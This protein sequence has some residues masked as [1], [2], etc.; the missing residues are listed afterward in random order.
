M[1]K[2]G[3]VL[4]SLSAITTYAVRTQSMTQDSYAEFFAG[5]LENVSLDN[6]GGLQP[7]PA[8][9]EVVVLE[10][11]VIFSAVADS[12]GTLYLGTGNHGSVYRLDPGA[13][14]P[15]LLF[16]P[17]SIMTRALAIDEAGNLY[18]GTSPDGAVYRISPNGR[19]E[20][21]FDPPGLYI[22]D[23]KF[24]DDGNLYVATGGDAKIYKLPPNFGLNDEPIEYFSSDRT[25]FTRMAWDRNGDLIVGSG[26]DAYLYRIKGEGEGEVLYSSG[27]EE[28]AN[29]AVVDDD[30]Y[31]TT[32]HKKSSED[33]PTTNLAE[34]LAKFLGKA[35]GDDDDDDKKDENGASKAPSFLLKLDS[36][37]FVSPVWSPGGSNIQ[38][39]VPDNKS[40]FWIG[41]DKNGRIYS[42]ADSDSWSLVNQAPREG[43]VSAILTNVG[44]DLYTYVCTSNPA[45][46]YRLNGKATE[47]LPK[48]TSEPIDAGTVA[49]WGRLRPLGA[50]ASSEGITFETRSGNASEPDDTWSDWTD[51]DEGTVASPPARFL[52]YRVNFADSK[53][54]LNGLTAYFGARNLAP[55]VAEVNV[56]PAGLNIVTNV[57]P[58]RPPINAKELTNSSK[59]TAALA[60]GPP[61]STKVVVAEDTGAISVAWSAIDPNGDQLS[62]S[63]EIKEEDEDDWVLFSDE[64]MSPAYSTPTR[65]FTD[66]YY[67]FRINASDAPSN[68]PSDTLTGSM[69]SRPFLIDNTSPEIKLH[70]QTTN[71]DGATVLVFVAS[72]KWAIINSAGYRLNGQASVEAVPTDAL[73]DSNEEIFRLVLPNLKSGTNSIVFKAVDELGNR[74]VSKATFQVEDSQ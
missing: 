25:H 5:D 10:D 48:Y 71:S 1:K 34:L 2:I 20:V 26:P 21:Y 28:I 45:V 41:S 54:R 50:P 66:G 12:K 13:E 46:V 11:S 57:S 44:P 49:R 61:K 36:E 43:G 17:D 40:G 63:V 39:L 55:L 6:L 42:V 9:D 68:I 64:Q 32:W 33:K 22:W 60:K 7:G 67:R 16:N 73:F 27:T 14:E 56:I 37:G 69:I 47:D 59:V 72:D 52:Q 19:P 38:Y 30:I 70:N 31:F 58:V 23:L 4:L 24:D 62:Y 18:A 3:L 51:L 65:G 8:L 35:N 29:V 74:G 15:T 53:A